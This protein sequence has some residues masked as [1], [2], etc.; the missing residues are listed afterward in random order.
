MLSAILC[1]QP[2][3][4]HDLRHCDGIRFAHKRLFHN[5]VCI[6]VIPIK[7]PDGGLKLTHVRGHNRTLHPSQLSCPDALASSLPD[8][9]GHDLE[10]DQ[11]KLQGEI[12]IHPTLP[13]YS[14]LLE[15]GPRTSCPN[16]AG[17]PV[18]HLRSGLKAA[19]FALDN[20][21]SCNTGCLSDE[22]A[23]AG[24]HG[25]LRAVLRFKLSAQSLDVQLDCHFL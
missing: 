16:H 19:G 20:D 14:D 15:S 9:R 1:R 10:V 24:D 21:I 25:S 13:D 3:S 5:L 8:S 23:I 18:R 17:R 22:I 4:C 2:A 7:G 12:G 6:R 11:A